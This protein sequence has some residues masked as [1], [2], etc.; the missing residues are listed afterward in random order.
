MTAEVQ[1]SRSTGEGWLFLACWLDLA[2]RE[3]VGYAMA[4]HHRADL[5]V[6]ALRMAHGRGGLEPGRIMHSDRGSE[7]TSAE[8]QA[9]LRTSGLRQSTGR[10]APS[11][12]TP[13]SRAFTPDG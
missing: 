1:S 7:Y 6:D 13:P 8:L 12:T 2:T 9:A 10:T 4:D 5:V 11:W 3:A